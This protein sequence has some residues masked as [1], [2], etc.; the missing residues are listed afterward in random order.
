MCMSKPQRVLSCSGQEAV[1][2]FEGQKR[3][4][5]TPVPLKEGEWVLCSAGQVAKRISAKHA[6]E[7]LKEWRELNDF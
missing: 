1:V 3:K 6:E 2:D 7:M 5:K 4:V